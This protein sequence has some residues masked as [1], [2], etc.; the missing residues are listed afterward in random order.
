VSCIGTLPFFLDSQGCHHQALG[1]GNIR[2]SNGTLIPDVNRPAWMGNGTLVA[3]TTFACHKNICESGGWKAQSLTG[4]AS[5]STHNSTG[6]I[7]HHRLPNNCL[8]L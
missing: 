5:S 3:T 2:L 4:N 8:K 7:S 1:I 6:G